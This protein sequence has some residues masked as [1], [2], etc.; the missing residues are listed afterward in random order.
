[1]AFNAYQNYPYVPYQ[2]YYQPYIA[3]TPNIPTQQ[4]QT[5]QQAPQT[6]PQIKLDTVSGKTAADVYNVGMGEEVILFDIDSPVVYKKHRGLDNKLDMQIFDLTP[7][8]DEPKEEIPKVNLD[9]YIKADAVEKIVTDRVKEELDKRLSEIS[10]TPK[11]TRR[12][13][14][15]D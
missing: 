3:P 5:P 11:T 14:S 1:M 4:V 15:E 6:M 13:K 7:H 9:E 12:N 2:P 8:I 10:F